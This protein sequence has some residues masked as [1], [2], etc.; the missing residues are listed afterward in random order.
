MCDK[1]RRCVRH[2]DQSGHKQYF[3]V[4]CKIF[5][6]LYSDGDYCTA[7]YST[8]PVCKSPSRA[9]RSLSLTN[10]PLS[11]SYSHTLCSLSSAVASFQTVC[12]APCL[13][14]S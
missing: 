3:R 5:L 12:S 13:S 14:S 11:L 6:S 1:C 2:D 4:P 9:P 7:L 8:R 10:V